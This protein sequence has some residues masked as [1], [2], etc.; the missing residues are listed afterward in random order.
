V[1]IDAP[2]VVVGAGPAGLAATH[3][4]RQHGI[5]AL[6]LEREPH[7][8][9]RIRTI[10]AHGGTLNTGAAFLASFYRETL[11]ICEEIGLPLV[12]PLIH[13]SRSHD[14]RHMVTP[15]GTFP[16]GPSSPSAFARFPPV[17]PAQK[18]R[19]LATIAWLL[20]G[21]RLHIADVGSLARHDRGDADRWARRVIGD[22]ACDYLVRPA[23]EPFFYA[24]ADEV[25]AAVAM[26]LLRHAA[27]W[28]LVTPRDG[29]GALCDRLA[30]ETTVVARARAVSVHRRVGD[31]VVR[32]PE[33][34][35]ATRSV[36]LAGTAPDMLSLDPPIDAG[37]IAD[38]R[39]VRYV[40][41]IVVLFGYRRELDI[42]VPSLTVGGPGR[43]P[44]VGFTALRTGGAPG[45]V[46]SGM[47]VVSVL[48]MGW[49]SEELAHAGDAEIAGAVIDEVAALGVELPAP[50]WTTIVRRREAT[51]VP[52]AGGLTR[53]AQC[54]ARP[55]RG[56]QLAGDWLAGCST[57]EGAVRTGLHAADAVAA[58]LAQV[59]EHGVGRRPS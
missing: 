55:R 20:L 56:V 27:R 17:P 6:V 51:V 8:G 35:V 5:E 28:R 31:F 54:A 45:A 33:R 9:G 26:A 53:V 1:D 10:R 30:R 11:R 41:C 21:T 4:L 59:R 43:H 38:M 13:P 24:G 23:I 22:D 44:L 52:A 16:F 32:T 29:M 46:P 12:E 58:D 48:T 25:S 50:D 15:G 2:C 39:A 57:V 47:E 14:K 3:R 18:V 49:R 19:L 40:P 42:P 36:I 7:V 34:A 37:D